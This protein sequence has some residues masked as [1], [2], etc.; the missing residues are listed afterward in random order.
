MEQSRIAQPI[1]SALDRFI[2]SNQEQFAYASVDGAQLDMD[3]AIT[4][5]AVA[6]ELAAAVAAKPLGHGRADIVPMLEGFRRSLKDGQVAYID[7]HVDSK[8]RSG[9]SSAIAAMAIDHPYNLAPDL[10]SNRASQVATGKFRRC[11]SSCFS[12]MS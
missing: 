8:A 3:H 10:V 12:F 4:A 9:R 5:R 11:R 2:K 1:G 7:E 6:E